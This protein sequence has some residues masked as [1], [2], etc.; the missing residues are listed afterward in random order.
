[1]KRK[2]SLLHR[3]PPVKKK[4]SALPEQLHITGLSHEG[5]GIAR[6]E[7]KT[8][9]VS[10]ALPGETIKFQ[11]LKQHRRFDEAHCTEI[12]EA[13]A[14]RAEPLCPHYTSCGGCDLQH[15]AP[16]VQLVTKQA[17]VLDQLQRLGGVV[18]E[19]VE[20]AIE[21]PQWNYRRSCRIGI[22]QRQKDGSALVGFRRRGSNK[23]TAIS[24]CA[25]AEPEINLLLKGL[26][27][28]LACADQFRQ[29][30]HAE[31]ILGDDTGILLLRVK[32]A[33]P[34]TL[35]QALKKLT[36]EIQLGL[37]LQHDDGE[38]VAVG[39]FQ[40]ILDYALPSFTIKL[41][42]APG[43]FIQINAQINRAMVD[44]A[45]N[46]LAIESHERVL[47]LFSGI[48]NFTLPM[49]TQADTV[50]GIEGADNMVARAQANAQLNQLNNC[51]FY[52][53]DLSADLRAQ[54][55]FKQGFDKILL[56]P[57]RTGAA[58]LIEQ[59]GHYQAKAILYVSCNP[60]ALARDAAA[61]GKQ[62]YKLK[63]FCVMDM[64]PQ[65]SHIESLALFERN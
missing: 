27:D 62:G 37:C 23:L 29:I 40:P 65:T 15:L 42:F 63:R 51:E 52:R 58:E 55:W 28:A 8:I 47:D 13:S 54:P 12:I 48:G 59:I 25:V 31:V 33:L 19:Q 35:L 16:V 7:G 38:I 26:P 60:A 3:R 14:D 44:R 34:A 61:L 18:P 17:L 5:R 30:T 1:M 50:V 39:N 43:D 32:K 20:A 36:T 9:F 45:L 53:A 10:G 21:G 49:A 64:F 41:Q 4:P 2:P 57:P 22:N 6:H 46:W 56:D 11:L 24:T